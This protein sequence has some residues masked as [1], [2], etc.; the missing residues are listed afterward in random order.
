MRGGNRQQL[1]LK[2]LPNYRGWHPQQPI[3]QSTRLC[4]G[5]RTP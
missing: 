5:L 1:L 3:T 4:E 2:L